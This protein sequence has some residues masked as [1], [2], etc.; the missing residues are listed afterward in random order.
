MK[1]N[2]LYI[3]KIECC[4]AYHLRRAV[5]LPAQAT[6]LVH[7]PMPW[8]ELPIVG[9]ASLETTEEVDKG[10]RITTVKLQ[11]KICRS[12][13]LPASPL[14]FRITD[15]HGKT[16]LLGT[17]DAPHPVVAISMQV[18]DNPRNEA[19]HVFTLQEKSSLGLLIIPS[20][21]LA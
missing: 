18:A 20:P 12:V 3:R 11:A 19:T 6:A 15:V 4:E 5:I 16:F 14:S 9:L 2:L 21:M 8:L 17:A 13:T 7:E 10:V 1:P